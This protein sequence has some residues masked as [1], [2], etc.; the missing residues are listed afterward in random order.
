MTVGASGVCGDAPATIA[1]LRKLMNAVIG[2][3]T[4]KATVAREGRL[5]RIVPLLL[6]PLDGDVAAGNVATGIEMRILSA[7]IV[8][9]LALSLIHI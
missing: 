8:G 9:S 6:A 1:E 2:N 5:A 3:R 4:Y 7:N